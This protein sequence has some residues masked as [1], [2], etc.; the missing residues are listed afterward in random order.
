MEYHGKHLDDSFIAHLVSG[1]NIAGHLEQTNA[2]EVGDDEELANFLVK[3][4][5][6][7][8][9]YVEGF[10]PSREQKFPTPWFEYIGARLRE[11]FMSDTVKSQTGKT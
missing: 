7:Y 4:L 5:E 2:I 10:T 11:G 9:G 3:G 8:D 6:A 1:A